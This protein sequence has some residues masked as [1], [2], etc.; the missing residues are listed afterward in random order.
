VKAN[1]QCG[2][3]FY[4]PI[5]VEK[6]KELV[7]W[8]MEQINPIDPLTVKDLEFSIFT[9]K[10]TDINMEYA[11]MIKMNTTEPLYPTR[12]DAIGLKIISCFVS[13]AVNYNLK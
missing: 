3:I 4:Y 6:S 12:S 11:L 7:K 10:D 2:R 8:K 13:S 9:Q 1:G 5:E